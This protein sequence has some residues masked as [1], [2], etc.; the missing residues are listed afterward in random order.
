MFYLKS[1]LIN[2]Q[3]FLYFHLGAFIFY[4]SLGRLNN[5]LHDYGVL[6]LR[7]SADKGYIK[8]SYLLG[9]RLKYRGTNSKYRVQSIDYLRKAASNDDGQYQFMLA[10]ALK[11]T[12]LTDEIENEILFLYE[13]AAKQGYKMAELRLSEAHEQG[14]FGLTINQKKA[15]Y[16]SQKFL[17]NSDYK[18]QR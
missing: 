5:K 14:L 2:C 17:A 9:V 15:K 6:C 18:S 16:W 3:A 4:S 8:A 11:D 1:V 7:R 10:E 12:E 13:S